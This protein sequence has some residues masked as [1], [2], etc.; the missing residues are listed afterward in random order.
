MFGEGLMLGVH[1]PSGWL[2]PALIVFGG[3]VFVGLLVLLLVSG[4]RFDE[5]SSVVPS[6]PGSCQPF[7]GTSTLA[8]AN[9][10]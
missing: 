6:T 7:C 10:G 8:P 9:P 1:L 2:W 3:V 4:A 5:P